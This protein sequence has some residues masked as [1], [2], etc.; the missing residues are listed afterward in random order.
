MILIPDNPSRCSSHPIWTPVP[1]SLALASTASLWQDAPATLT[2]MLVLSCP[3]LGSSLRYSVLCLE[4]SPDPS[5]AH[6]SPHSPKS[7]PPSDRSLPV[8]NPSS[9]LSPTFHHFLFFRSVLTRW[10]Y[11]VNWFIFYLLPQ[12]KSFGLEIFL[13]TLKRPCSLNWFSES[14][15]LGTRNLGKGFSFFGHQ[16]FLLGFNSRVSSALLL[17]SERHALPRGCNFRSHFQLLSAASSPP[18]LNKRP[19]SKRHSFIS[20]N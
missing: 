4:I 13:K 9:K 2:S 19:K 3:A 18:D 7:N 15:G 8:Y 5:E 17:K 6:V 16:G 11:L 20:I 12:R 14:R 1:S 10:H